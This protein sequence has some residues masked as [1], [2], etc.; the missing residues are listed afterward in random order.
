MPMEQPGGEA[1]QAVENRVLEPKKERVSGARD[2]GI[3]GIQMGVQVIKHLG[4]L[5]ESTEY[6][7]KREQRATP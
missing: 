7:Q 5:M 1:Q 6:R 3:A 4:L 2:V